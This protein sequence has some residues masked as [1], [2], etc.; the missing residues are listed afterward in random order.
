MSMPHTAH[1]KEELKIGNNIQNLVKPKTTKSVASSKSFI[2]NM[3][4]DLYK[5]TGF[6]ILPIY[7]QVIND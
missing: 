1:H 7:E 5:K 3:S 2:A 4:I 6:L